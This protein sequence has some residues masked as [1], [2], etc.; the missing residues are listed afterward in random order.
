MRK[1]PTAV[2]SINDA[3]KIFAKVVLFAAL[4]RKIRTLFML[5]QTSAHNGLRL[6]GDQRLE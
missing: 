4:R 5:L 2:N 1:P 6:N 3:I